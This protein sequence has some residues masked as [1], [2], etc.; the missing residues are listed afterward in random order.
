LARQALLEDGKQAKLEKRLAKMAVE[1]T[2]SA[3]VKE[4]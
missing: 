2:A 1:S 3:P 4:K